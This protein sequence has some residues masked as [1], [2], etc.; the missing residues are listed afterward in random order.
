MASESLRDLL[1]FAT[2]IAWHAGKITLSYFQTGV[3]A[4]LKADDSPVT[5]ADREAEQY[6]R[7][8]IGERYPQHGILGEEYGET[9]AG[10]SH[11]WILDPIDGTKSFVRG[12]PLYGVLI[13]VEREGQAV[14]GVVYIPPLDEMLVA[15]QGLGC[16]HNG[17]RAHVSPCTQLDE[18]LLLTYD[19]VEL[20][21]RQQRAY[22]R[23][24]AA[25]KLQRTWGDCYAYLLVATGRA[26][27]AID[28]VMNVWDC[29]PMLPILQEAG[30]TFTD[31]A[32]TPT[33]HGGN[34]VATNGLLFDQVMQIMREP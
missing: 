3:V 21:R 4:D 1:D 16:Y 9:N 32:G 24:I 11:R 6:L 7:Q 19:L 17:R 8:A 33:I 2:S 15:A 34:A 5:I 14:A 27:I 18:A 13:G 29:G 22:Q 31:L 25:T 30:G 10:A 20:E 26:E 12:V 28:P 23:L